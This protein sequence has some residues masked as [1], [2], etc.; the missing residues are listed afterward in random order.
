M[1]YLEMTMQDKLDGALAQATVVFSCDL[2]G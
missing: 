2:S 1:P